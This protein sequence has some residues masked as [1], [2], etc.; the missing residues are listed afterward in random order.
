MILLKDARGFSSIFNAPS[1]LRCPRA[2]LKG[3]K[4]LGYFPGDETCIL[5]PSG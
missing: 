1:G 5:T 3:T 4:S 2:E